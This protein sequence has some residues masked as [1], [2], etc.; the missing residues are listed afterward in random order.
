M[1]IRLALLLTLVL[2]ACSPSSA[3]APPGDPRPRVA[4]LTDIGGD[5]DDEQ[6]LVRFLLYTNELDVEALICTTST[7][8]KYTLQPKL[9]RE[10]IAAY[11]KVRDRLNEHVAHGPAP[12]N[13]YPSAD[14]LR[15][16]IKL[17]N[18]DPKHYG[19]EAVGDGRS[20]EGSRWL[21]TLADRDDPRPLWVLCWGGTNTLAQT[22]WDARK[23]RSPRE[24]EQLIAKLRVYP[25]SAQDSSH[26]WLM[27]NF[28]A[29]TWLNAR[30]VWKGFSA[31]PNIM[32]WFGVRGGE[33]SLVTDAWADK[34]IR[35]KGP[36]GKLYPKI[37]YLMEGDTPS[38]LYLVSNGLNVPDRPGYGGWGGRFSPDGPHHHDKVKD[39]V[40]EF[41]EI[42][43]SVWRWR[44]AYQ[45]DFIARMDWTV[46][47]F[48]PANHP[49]RPELARPLRRTVRSGQEVTLDA[50]ASADVDGDELTFRWFVYREASGHK[51]DVPIRDADRPRARLTAPSVPSSRTVHVILELTDDGTP[52]L[53]R[54]RRVV[55][56]VTPK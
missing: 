49:P 21:A 14:R 55:L 50:S 43:A 22:L 45:N 11:A 8:Q 41:R 53:T 44:Q 25:I 29:L 54:Y 51:G 15:S 4:V 1:I 19:M 7:S 2:M 26:G 9:I 30:N 3:D 24:L 16:V 13:Q 6:S 32:D 38:F 52:P 34:H 56:T 39:A 17:G 40:G 31:G 27:K 42:G 37:A 10:R 35:P 48:D 28:P 20:S 5:P 33:E 12:Y 47:P 36:L 18:V 23:N 46:K